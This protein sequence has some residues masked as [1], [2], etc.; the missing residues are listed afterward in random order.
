MTVDSLTSATLDRATQ[1]FNKTNQMNLST[2]RLANT[3]LMAWAAADDHSV[4]TCRV[5]DRFGDSGLTG[6]VGLEFEGPRA[7]L[8]DFVLSCRVMGRNVEETLL[9][10]AAAH[11]RARGAAELVA[12][13]RPT[14]R[15][16]P[17]LEFFRRS[18]FRAESDGRFVWGLSTRYERP[19]WVTVRD[20]SDVTR[21]GNPA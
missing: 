7:R 6:L 17:C 3:E 18:G 14:S 1:L 13:F 16:A 5:A 20:H 15:N 9:H 2:R 12:E 19:P 4:L 11:A 21:A 8:V 10:V